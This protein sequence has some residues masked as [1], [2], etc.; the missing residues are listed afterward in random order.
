ML[1]EAICSSHLN[2]SF[3][4][5]LINTYSCLRLLL[6]LNVTAFPNV[7]FSRVVSRKNTLLKTV[8]SLNCLCFIMV[9]VSVVVAVNTASL[10]NTDEHVFGCK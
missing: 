9:T 5:S 10:N 8:N 3:K 6:S 7:Q 4:Y 1:V 2:E